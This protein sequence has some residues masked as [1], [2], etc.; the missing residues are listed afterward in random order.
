M[1]GKGRSDG[2]ADR[3][4]QA[5]GLTVTTLGEL[6]EELGKMKLGRWVLEEIAG[7]LSGAGLGHFPPSVLDPEQNSV[8]RQHQRVWVYERDGGP[9]ARVID[10][11]L[12][13][14]GHD[15]SGV[16]DGIVADRLAAL[17]PEQK[18]DRIRDIVDAQ[19]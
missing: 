17:T 2:I 16:L 19:P 12:D 7:L 15:V 3:C 8:P 14:E 10:A 9:R 13:P 1:G 5:G 11:I 6:R 18:L 4:K